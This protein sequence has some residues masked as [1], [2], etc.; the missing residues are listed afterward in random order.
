[1]RKIINLIILIGSLA[2]NACSDAQPPLQPSN[3]TPAVSIEA[4]IFKS[5]EVV[6]NQVNILNS[7]S[8][9]DYNNV[10]KLKFYFEPE[11]VPE[12]MELYEIR[13]KGVYCA[14]TFTDATSD[15]PFVYNDDDEFTQLDFVWYRT[16]K[17]SDLSNTLNSFS[18]FNNTYGELKTDK[19][20]YFV[21]KVNNPVH[22]DNGNIVSSKD[23]C[24]MI[25][26]AQEGMI[27]QVNAPL[28]FTDDD[29]AKYCIAKKVTTLE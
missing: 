21:Q 7:K 27:F 20:I 9:S 23:V 5:K 3:P 12:N 15:R 18:G 29:I 16:Q 4:D 14:L 13:V 24:Y 6:V 25:I 10:K 26:W 22:D 17:E 11:A 1:M 28:W 19:I 8:E 2:L